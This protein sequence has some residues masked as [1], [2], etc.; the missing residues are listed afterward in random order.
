LILNEVI[1]GAGVET[2]VNPLMSFVAPLGVDK[3]TFFAPTVPAGVVTNTDVE[4]STTIDVPGTSPNKT[5]VVPDRNVPVTR[6]ALPPKILPVEAETAEILGASVISP[7]V[8]GVSLE[9]EGKLAEV[10]TRLL[11]EESLK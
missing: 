3:I 6:I 7:D 2:Y 4:L 5:W 8:T 10:K 1:V 9:D 11:D